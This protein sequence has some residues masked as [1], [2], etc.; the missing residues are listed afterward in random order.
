[1]VCLSLMPN[2]Q[3]Q[4]SIVVLMVEIS[5]IYFNHKELF[6]VIVCGYNKV[7]FGFVVIFSEA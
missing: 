2:C 4:L 3:S 1:M 6:E 5:E 7:L